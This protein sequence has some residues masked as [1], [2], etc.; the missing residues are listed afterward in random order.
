VIKG[1]EAQR[2]QQAQEITRLGG[3]QRWGTYV[4]HAGYRFTITSLKLKLFTQTV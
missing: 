4:P 1:E 3:N 2:P